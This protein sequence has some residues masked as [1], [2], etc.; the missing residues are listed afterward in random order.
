MART[1]T[2]PSSAARVAG[3]VY[4]QIVIGGKTYTLSQPQRVG[5]FAKMEAF[6]ISRR[7]D[8]IQFAIRACRQTPATMHAAIWEGCSATGSRGLASG[9]EWDTF[10]RSLWKN[11]FMLWVTLDPKHADEVPTIEAAMELIES[12]MDLEELMALIKIVSQDS[13]LPN[14]FGRTATAAPAPNQPTADRSSPDG[15]QSMNS[16]DAN[17][18]SAPTS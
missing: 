12:G 13:D 6:I 8:P 7:T 2:N 3:K 4:K 11:A 18:D 10:E 15:Q 17:S 16:S 14:S 5:N 9:A 1:P